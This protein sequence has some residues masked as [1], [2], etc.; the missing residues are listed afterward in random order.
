LSDIFRTALAPHLPAELIRELVECYKE[1]KNNFYLG[2]YRPNE[3]EGGR[4]SEA[5]FRILEYRIR[6]KYT[7]LGK[8]L[9]T[10][11]IIKELEALPSSV[12]PDSVRIH[13]PR[14]LRVIYDIRNKRDAAHL[15]DK[16]DP[17]LQDATL[18]STCCD[19]IMAELLRLY[20]G[21]L[22]PDQAF[23]IIEEL[24]TKKV[25]VIQEF[26]AFLKTL[27]PSIGT[28]S[29]AL[30]LLYHRGTKGATLDELVNWI[31]PSQKNNLKAALEKLENAKDL[32]VF[33][34]GKYFI[35]L[36]GSKEVEVQRL[37]DPDF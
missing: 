22:S 35:T 4:F 28:Q 34:D 16:I 24:V 23:K 3:V 29:R 21:S 12:Q 27:K 7:P 2:K 18:V 13:I 20:H 32:I 33:H 9:V 26:G 17:N 37:L 14:T 10:E 30:V 36:R 19:W 6:K 5:V 15:G 8:K 25:P 1:T 31:K 11:K